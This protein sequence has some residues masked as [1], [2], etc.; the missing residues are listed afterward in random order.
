[1]A[2]MAIDKRK[3]MMF[4]FV[5]FDFFEDSR[6]WLGSGYHNIGSGP[7]DLDFL[8]CSVEDAIVQAEAAAILIFS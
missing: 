1:M 8:V 3:I 6:I 4:V 2:M 5:S 7:L